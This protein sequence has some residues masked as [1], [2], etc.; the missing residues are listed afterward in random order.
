MKFTHYLPRRVHDLILEHNPSF[1]EHLFANSD[2]PRWT[3][4]GVT[5]TM[6]EDTRWGLHNNMCAVIHELSRK[7]K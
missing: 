4:A 2:K 7:A 3:I 5:V 1:I 6:D